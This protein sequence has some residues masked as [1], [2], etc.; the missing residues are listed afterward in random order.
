MIINTN[1]S[2]F[3][4]KHQNK[5]NQI[6]FHITACKNNNVIENII[7]NVL[8]KKNSFI[9]ESVEKRKYRGRYTI[10]GSDPD[11]IWE[12]NNNKITLIENNI[13]RSIKNN[14]Y[15]YLKKLIENFNFPLP[16]NIPS[17]C[18]LLVG[19]FS[20]DIIRYIEKIPNNCVD[21][22]K[23]PDIRLMRPKNIIIHDNLKKKIYFIVNCFGDQKIKNYK[24]YFQKQLQVIKYFKKQAFTKKNIPLTKK[25]K[26]NKSVVKSNIS[27]KKFRDIV[28]KAKKYIKK[29]DIFQVVL[30]QRFESPLTK[31]P[32]EIYKKLRINNPSPF[33]FFFNFQDFQIIGSS[34][35]ILV[36]LRDGKITIRPI[37]GTRPRGKNPKKDKFYKNQLLNDK[38][39]LSEHLMLLDLGRND[40]GKV[41]KI[42]SVKVTEEFKIEKYSHVMHIV[43]NVEGKFN[44]KFSQLDTMF[45]GFPAG[46]VT[47][48]PKIRAM[49]I[50]DELEKS[51]RKMYAGSIGY[52]TANKSFDT[53][54]ALRTALIKDN[55]FY[56]QSGA[57][58]V[59]DSVP[60][61]EYMETINKA[62]ALINSL[63]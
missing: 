43:S 54:I 23:I 27:K 25:I 22:L 47:G 2:N 55:K 50:I 30:S 34:P 41:S 1:F 29:G 35:E 40:V 59:A 42:N 31:K 8:V 26:I 13:K 15:T 56:I 14:P 46:T 12:F 38:K 62:K 33:M 6:L 24:S 39:E 18:S 44:K 36:R 11:K 10:I 48:A 58:I 19:Y 57:G 37:A 52:F 16:K 51:K 3:K 61:K 17:L 32:L 21:D 63:N 53:C 4:K 45:S 7:N 20:Y 49:E 5:K 28:L 9:F 60:E